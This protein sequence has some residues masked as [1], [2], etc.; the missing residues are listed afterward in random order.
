MKVAVYYKNDDVRLEERPKPKAGPKE[1]LIK[2]L[3]SGICGSDVL[4]WYRMKKAPIV[5]GHEIAG[6]IVELGKDV[7]KFKVGQRVFASHHVP[8]N[9]CRY[10]LAGD[11]TACH[12]LQT[13]NFDPGGFSEFV[14]IP[15]LQTDR[16]IFVLPDEMSYEEGTFVEPLGCVVRGQRAANIKAADSVLVLGSGLSGLL[17]IATAKALG[18][19][20]IFATDINDYRLEA[21]KK[22]GAD[23]VFN[24]REDIPSLVK[25]S[26]DGRL[27]DKIFACAGVPSVFDQA[28]K[29][30]DRGGVVQCFA[31]TDPGVNL[32]V[33]VN[34]FWRN[35]MTLQTSYGAA[36]YDCQVAIDLIRSRRIPVA[37]MITHR[38]PLDKTP[39]GF[40]MVA[41]AADCIK[42]IIEPHK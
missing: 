25:K 9:T 29:S 1:V 42:V 27:V 33:P 40:K 14:R 24:A 31:T 7:E 3:A 20:K 11:H 16:G 10:C 12:T 19:A 35:S 4:Q 23:Y 2:I 13:T 36:P 17:H 18:A 39:E 6:N 41:R 28:M 5:L 30:A 38:L 34:E 37:D 8:C 32:C 21:A 15:E 26:N 22:F